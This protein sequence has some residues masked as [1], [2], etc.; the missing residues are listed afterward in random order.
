M[1][2]FIQAH[3]HFF[4]DATT[5]SYVLSDAARSLLLHQAP[6]MYMKLRLVGIKPSLT[7]D[8]RPSHLDST[9]LYSTKKYT[10]ASK[11]SYRAYSRDRNAVRVEPSTQAS[12]SRW[13]R[14]I[15]VC[16]ELYW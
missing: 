16:S 7:A 12:G 6:P 5:A 4:H 9:T 14:W 11:P 2:R 10:W 8:A 3:P 13:I 15:H 1:G